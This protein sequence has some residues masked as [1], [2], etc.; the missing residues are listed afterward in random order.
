M[1]EAEVSPASAAS[2]KMKDFEKDMILKTLKDVQGNKTKAAKILGVSVRTI[3]NKLHEYG[4][5]FPAPQTE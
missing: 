5:F 3:R 1:I 4:N 2:G